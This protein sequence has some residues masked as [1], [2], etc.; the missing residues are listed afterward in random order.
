MQVSRIANQLLDATSLPFESPYPSL[1]PYD[2]PLSVPAALPT[3]QNPPG[4]KRPKGVKKIDD[5]QKRAKLIQKKKKKAKKAK[6][7]EGM[8]E[9]GG[10]ASRTNDGEPA[11]SVKDKKS[12]KKRKKRKVRHENGGDMDIDGEE[13]GLLLSEQDE[14][15]EDDEKAVEQ[16]RLE[17]EAARLAAEKLEQLSW[18]L[19]MDT[20]Q[21]SI[22]SVANLAIPPSTLPSSLATRRPGTSH[23]TSLGQTGFEGNNETASSEALSRRTANFQ[24]SFSRLAFLQK[25]KEQQKEREKAE[26][27]AAIQAAQ[28]ELRKKKKAKEDHQMQQQQRDLQHQQLLL[29]HQQLQQ[30]QQQQAQQAQQS[31]TDSNGA[32]G[33]GDIAI[34]QSG[35]MSSNKRSASQASLQSRQNSVIDVPVPGSST[36]AT[37]NS[38]PATGG[39]TNQAQGPGGSNATANPPKTKKG[40]KAAAKEAK[41]KEAKE[42]K[43]AKEN[44]KAGAAN[45]GGGAADNSASGPSGLKL[46]LPGKKKGKNAAGKAGS[47][48]ISVNTSNGGGG[49]PSSQQLPPNSAASNA[50]NAAQQQGGSGGA[51]G[52]SQPTV[53]QQ[54]INR[55]TANLPKAKLKSDVKAAAAGQNQQ[56]PSNQQQQ[57]Q[58][59][60][61]MSNASPGTATS[62]VPNAVQ[63]MVNGLMLP[64]TGNNDGSQNQNNGSPQRFASPLPINNMLPGQQ[65]QGN[66]NLGNL[67]FANLN[68]AGGMNAFNQQHFAQPNQAQ[69]QAFQQAYMNQL[70]QNGML[71]GRQMSSSP[72]GNS[73]NTNNSATPNN[74]SFMNIHRSPVYNNANLPNQHGQG[75]NPYQPSGSP[76]AQQQQQNAAQGGFS[77]QQAFQLQQLQQQQQQL[78][79]HQ[80]ALQAFSSSMPQSFGNGQIPNNALNNANLANLFQQIQQQVNQ[81]GGGGGGGGGGSQGPNGQPQIQ[82]PPPGQQGGNAGG[83]GMNMPQFNATLLN[84]LRQQQLM[85]GQ[86]QQG[87][88]NGQQ[89]GGAANQ[90]NWNPSQR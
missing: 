50:S 33:T 53:A 36:A 40:K 32:N 21:Y 41:E 69:A 7:V 24:A 43:E 8:E 23:N 29:Q 45:G 26:R 46:T 61:A 76:S 78:H 37:D 49:L 90:M 25:Y 18:M 55:K 79:Q 87:G 12:K 35:A 9:D 88:F 44:A 20:K 30:Q 71:Q 16:A 2:P 17:A 77:P 70:Q 31:N 68:G 59:S 72:F 80:Q 52:A 1:A 86:P 4:K 39:A 75:Y 57:G 48:D 60:P 62:G 51:G 67:N 42:A 64:S 56:S 73:S 38:E 84:Q 81:S 34:P 6:A 27:E 19:V 47:P 82:I 66:F 63:Q 22:T 11:V 15:G 85:A 89:G 58:G 74:N 5:D 14:E 13:G 10:E 65:Q 28:E 83:G 54:A 3:Q